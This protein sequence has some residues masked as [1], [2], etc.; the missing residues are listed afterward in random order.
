[1]VHCVVPSRDA[2]VALHAEIHAAIEKN[3]AESL[4]L[5]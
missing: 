2:N 1:V 3:V 4:G 5:G